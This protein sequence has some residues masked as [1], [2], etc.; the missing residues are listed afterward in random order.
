MICVAGNDATVYDLSATAEPIDDLESLAQVLGSRRLNGTGHLQ[1]LEPARL[2]ELWASVRPARAANWGRAELSGDAWDRRQVQ[3][4]GYWVDAADV[5]TV[6]RAADRTAAAVA[7]LWHLDR[8]V[9]AEPDRTENYAA[10]GR[11]HAA[12]GQWEQAVAD[13]TRAITGNID[14]WYERGTAYAE[15]GRWRECAADFRRA[16]DRAGHNGQPALS[17]DRERERQKQLALVLLQVGDV[18]EYRTICD[19]LLADYAD[20]RKE[21]GRGRDNPFPNVCLL[22]AR[23]VKDPARLAALAPNIDING[24]LTWSADLANTQ[25][26]AYYRA[27]KFEPAASQL[28]RLLSG[29]TDSDPA[30]WFFLAMAQHRLGWKDQAKTSLARGVQRLEKIDRTF[31][32]AGSDSGREASPRR[33]PIGKCAPCARSCAAK[34]R[35]CWPN[36][37]RGVSP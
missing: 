13:D 6:R 9:A 29:T 19:R 36:S 25:E 37:G 3:E 18:A 2:R 5:P 31:A 28:E 24:F 23:A 16:A 22:S 12:L 30:D 20:A 15:L 32:E 8:L 34:R 7:A 35:A 17:A 4:C 14:R 27:G 26:A 1:M 33:R 11:A 10:R 21:R